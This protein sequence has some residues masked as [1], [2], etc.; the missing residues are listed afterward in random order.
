MH[1]SCV[2]MPFIGLQDGNRVIPAQVQPR[3][4]VT[5]PECDGEMT[6]VK[7]HDKGSVHYVRHF[8]HLPGEGCGGA[9]ESD[10]HIRMKRIAASKLIEIFG[11][12]HR[13]VVDEEYIGR[14]E[15]DVLLEF[16]SPQFPWGRGICVEVQY[17]NKDKDIQATT[18]N[19]LSHEYSVFWLYPDDFDGTDV[20]M[21]TEPDRNRALAPWPHGVPG[22]RSVGFS[23]LDQ[24]VS[25]PT[26]QR[27]I[28]ELFRGHLIR[29]F[30]SGRR[31]RT[32]TR[33][34]PPPSIPQPD[35]P[36]LRVDLTEMLEHE[37]GRDWLRGRLQMLKQEDL[38]PAQARGEPEAM[39][40]FEPFIEEIR[41]QL[42]VQDAMKNGRI[43]SIVRSK[44][45]EL[46]LEERLPFLF[47]RTFNLAGR[48]VSLSVDFRKGQLTRLREGQQSFNPTLRT[49][50]RIYTS[51]DNSASTFNRKR[52]A[53][54]ESATNLRALYKDLIRSSLIPTE[55]SAP[56]P[57]MSGW[58]PPPLI[59]TLHRAESGTDASADATLVN[60]VSQECNS[61]QHG[62]CSLEITPQCECICHHV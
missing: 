56:N 21:P 6:T 30:L 41:R 45:L 61:G 39:A 22:R 47:Q 5:C 11:D 26:Y 28:R 60:G 7:A 27:D 12:E 2:D 33:P 52:L 29:A 46:G 23:P 34:R 32:E 38:V 4:R 18:W 58:A 49:K 42:A 8:S 14:N 17:R 53:G 35:P 50:A 36:E 62:D 10:E 44:L 16:D 1:P 25:E 59:R 40:N 15:P 57:S 54:T 48:E 51:I 20:A 31:K 13:L 19:F 55:E 37:F 24:F 43:P 9:E 3:S